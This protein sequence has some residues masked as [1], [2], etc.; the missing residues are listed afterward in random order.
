MYFEKVCADKERSAQ[1][2][3]ILSVDINTPRYTLYG[4]CQAS[5]HRLLDVIYAN[6]SVSEGMTGVTG[7]DMQ[8]LQRL[9]DSR[10]ALEQKVLA[11]SKSQRIHVRSAESDE[12]DCANLQISLRIRCLLFLVMSARDFLSG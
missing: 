3:S 1:P 12:A 4:I 9:R 8:P 5:Y 6:D 7:G 2:T 10:Y 11:Q